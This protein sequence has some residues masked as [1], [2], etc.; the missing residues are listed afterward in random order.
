M[1][2]VHNTP[3]LNILLADD[4]KDDRFFF[5]KALNE[6]PIR[7]QLTTVQN[8][9]DLLQFLYKHANELPDVLFLD[10]NMPRKSGAECLLLIKNH[11]KIKAMPVVIYSTSIYDDVADLLYQN[12][13]HYY[14]RKTDFS[15]LKVILQRV[16]KMLVENNFQ[17]PSEKEFIV[18][19]N[20]P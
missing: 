7:T 2:L 19:Q 8:G 18:L 15:L 16:L 5:Q 12:G 20:M 9:E 4:D 1:N 13:A 6:I 11:P 17:R 10:L 14:I 3:T